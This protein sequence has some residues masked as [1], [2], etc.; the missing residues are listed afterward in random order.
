MAV[1]G[2]GEEVVVSGVVAESRSY[3]EVVRGRGV[4]QEEEGGRQGKGT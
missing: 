2:L 1:E 3:S 4:R